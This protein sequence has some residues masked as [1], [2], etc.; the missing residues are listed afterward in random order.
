MIIILSS[1]WS[2]IIIILSSHWSMITNS[3]FSLVNDNN[4]VLSLARTRTD[5]HG[6]RHSVAV[7]VI[8][9]P[10][11]VKFEGGYHIERNPI[12][13]AARLIPPESKNDC[14]YQI[15]H[16]LHTDLKAQ[17]VLFLLNVLLR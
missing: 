8:P 13:G 3:V 4:T 7:P 10:D 11:G 2:M 9:P 17:P 6:R 1:H 15:V 12:T 16:I 5:Q 14:Q